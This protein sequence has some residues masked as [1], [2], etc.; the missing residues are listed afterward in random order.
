MQSTAIIIAAGLGTRMKSAMPKAAHKIAGQP[1]LSHL[2]RAAEQVFDRIAVV[3]GP[4]MQVLEQLAAPHAVAVQAER[5]GTAHATLQAEAFFGEGPVAV[6]YADNPL[7]SVETMRALLARLAQGDAG[8][9]LLGMTPPDAGKY[10]RL[11]MEGAYLSRIVEYADA[12]EAERAIGFCNAGGMAALG[13]D[14]RDWLA[15]VGNNNSKGEFYLTD[16][17]AIA[18]TEGM[19]VAAINAPFDECMG[20]NSRAEL[21]QAEAAFQTCARARFMAGGVTLLAPETVF[22]SA[23]TEIGADT[24]IGQHV[25]FGPGVQVDGNVEIKAFS[26]LEGCVVR[27]GAIIGPYARLRPGAEIGE[28]VHIGNFVEVKAAKLG[29]GVKANHLTYLG[30]SEIGPGTNIGAGTI[31]CNYDG[32]AK[33]RTKIGA[34][35]FIGSNTALVAPVS[36]GDGALVAAGSVINQNVPDKAL[37]L[38]RARQVNKPLKR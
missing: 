15:Q 37:A 5:L 8:L 22:F 17:V 24:V 16:I 6:F 2:I 12:N 28:D 1:M 7:V 20:V 25:V 19:N 35:A 26:H 30:D 13:T 33:H 31:T 38:G 36:V 29:R 4:G 18:R 10:G 11:V 32:K 21:A 14:M 23:D 9:V 34:N 27:S 3:V